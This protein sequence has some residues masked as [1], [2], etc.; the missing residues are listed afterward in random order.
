M[1]NNKFNIISK[2]IAISKG[3]NVLK[4][5]YEDIYWFDKTIKEEDIDNSF[6]MGLPFIAKTSNN[7]ILISKDDYSFIDLYCTKKV[8]KD[9]I[10]KNIKEWNFRKYLAKKYYNDTLHVCNNCNYVVNKCRTFKYSDMEPD[11]FG[12][13]EFKRKPKK[14]VKKLIDSSLFTTNLLD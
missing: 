11:Y 4:I 12:C 8:D 1:D 14:R 5:E 13:S 10:L 7:S 3:L 9:D 2:V 6:K